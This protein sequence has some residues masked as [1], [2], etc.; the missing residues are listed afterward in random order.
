VIVNLVIKINTIL[1]I[2]LLVLL[3]ISIGEYNYKYKYRITI[4]IRI[5]S[6]TISRSIT[7]R[8][9]KVSKEHRCSRKLGFK[10]GYGVQC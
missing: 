6:I 8:Q 10:V 5:D 3:S 9:T 7:V 1:K 2:K 4:T